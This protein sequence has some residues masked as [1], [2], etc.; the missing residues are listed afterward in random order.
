MKTDNPAK[1]TMSDSVKARLM[2]VALCLAW[3]LTWPAMRIALVD[4]PPFSM[5]AV[6]AF[7]GATSLIAL[8]WI[9]RRPVRIPPRSAWADIFIIGFFNI[10]VFSL[11]AAFAQLSAN[12]GRV[13]IL[14]YTMPIWATLLARVILKERLTVAR[15]FALLLCCVGM[16]AL[17]YPLASHGVPLGLLLALCAAV[18]WA[19]GTIYM[20]WKKIDIEPFTLAAWQL[21]ISFVVMTS[22]VPVFEPSFRLTD[23]GLYSAF[24][25]AFSGFFGSGVAYYLWF[26]I[27]RLLPATTASLGALASPVIGVVSSMVLLGER[28]TLSDTIGYVLIFA[29]SACVLLAPSPPTKVQPEHP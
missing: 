29:A 3:G 15:G 13:A 10:I 20:K 23:I 27:I 1:K 21:V 19:I 24:G 9:S 12:T 6:S 4:I 22:M 2:L 7:V 14:V 11:C 5:R 8:A 25:V 18:S 17:I 16:V 26:H 28:P